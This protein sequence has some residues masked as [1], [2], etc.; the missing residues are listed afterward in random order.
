MTAYRI[1]RPFAIASLLALVAGSASAEDNYGAIAFSQATGSYGYT[2]DYGS[3]GSAEQGA[4]NKCSGRCGIVLWFKNACGALATGSGSGYGTG[5]AGTRRRA[6]GVAMSN[7]R[8][9][10]GGCS[11]LAWACTTR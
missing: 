7:C 3:R 1:A 9:R 6:E 8:E 11:I 2:Y 10:T 5:W 4:I